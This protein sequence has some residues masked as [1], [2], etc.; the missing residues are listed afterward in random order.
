[1]WDADLSISHLRSYTG[2]NDMTIRRFIYLLIT[3][4]VS[5][6]TP[7]LQAALPFYPATC[8]LP[9]A[10]PPECAPGYNPP[11]YCLCADHDCVDSLTLSGRFDFLWWRAYEEGTTLGCRESFYGF[12]T[13]TEPFIRERLYNNSRVKNLHTH[14]DPG[15]RLGIDSICLCNGWDA[16]IVWTHFH[17]GASA[18]SHNLCDHRGTTFLVP[19]WERISGLF[20][21]K[22][23]ASWK[24]EMDLVDFEIG[25][26]FYA[27]S[28]FVLRPLIGIRTARIAQSYRTASYASDTGMTQGLSNV[29]ISKTKSTGTFLALGPRVGLSMEY[30]L[31]CGL[32]FFGEAA[33]SILFGRFDR[34]ANEKSKVYPSSSML[35]IDYDYHSS[36]G[37]DRVSRTLTDISVGI[38]YS[39]CFEWCNRLR[40]ISL[41]FAWEHHAF[42][43][44][45]SFNFASGTFSV[46]ER[47]TSCSCGKSGN[48]YTQGLVVSADVGF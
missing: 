36:T 26:K 2:P 7:T 3:L 24:L 13:R 15:F 18:R 40:K 43:H 4:T 12:I 30:R 20:P 17:T 14:Y 25:S 23:K 39:R 45:N 22:A 1:M 32:A 21:E 42:Y 27:S 10:A 11:A 6:I 9:P 35:G 34:H 28:C 48:L 31:G 46:T 16:A 37:C 47:A 38:D 41:S 44:L 19:A 8:F 33:T 5:T 29:F